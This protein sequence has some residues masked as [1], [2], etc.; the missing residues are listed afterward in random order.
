M[1][2]LNNSNG[3]YKG[4]KTALDSSSSNCS[5]SD[6]QSIL[7]LSQATARIEREVQSSQFAGTSQG[8]SCLRQL[9]KSVTER[10]SNCDLLEI[11]SQRPSVITP[12]TPVSPNCQ[13]SSTPLAETLPIAPTHS[14]CVSLGEV[15]VYIPP[16]SPT[17]SEISSIG[18]E[19]FPAEENPEP[20]L[21]SIPTA[22]LISNPSYQNPTM[23]EAENNLD[24]KLYLFRQSMRMY[25]ISH[26]H[27]G[28]ID[29]HEAKVKER[30]QM[31]KDTAIAIRTHLRKFSSQI[32]QEKM[33]ELINQI[34]ALEGEFLNYVGEP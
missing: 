5:V 2:D 6:L 32:A 26:L 20:I 1:A 22:K 19:V 18:G 21:H 8:Q 14:S 3:T 28:T 34:P 16:T 30:E 24:D 7:N 13:K 27:A 4:R 9:R 25:P 10:I 17:C 15:E 12:T 11:K 33:N 23:E 29:Q 31:L